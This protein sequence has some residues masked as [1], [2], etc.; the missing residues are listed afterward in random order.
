[1]CNMGVGSASV[2][3]GVGA[4]GREKAPCQCTST[5]REEGENSTLHTPCHPTLPLPSS[6]SH[7]CRRTLGRKASPANSS[8]NVLFAK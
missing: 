6:T 7:P 8:P 4:G 1:M 3:F 2:G 5:I